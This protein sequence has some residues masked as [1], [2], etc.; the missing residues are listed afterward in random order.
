MIKLLGTALFKDRLAK[1]L[2]AVIVIISSVFSIIFS[3]IQIYSRYQND[4]SSLKYNFKNIDTG[5]IH[6]IEESVWLFSFQQLNVILDGLSQQRDI[7]HLN[8]QTS[9]GHHFTR[10]TLADNDETISQKYP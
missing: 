5:Y 8:L 1:R 6:S 3:G 7:R 4:L 10:G 2:I 9:T